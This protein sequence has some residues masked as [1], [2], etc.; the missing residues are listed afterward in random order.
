M[1][2][3]DSNNSVT[4]PALNA[5]LTS[6][7]ANTDNRASM[8]KRSTFKLNKLPSIMEDDH[9]AFLSARMM[10]NQNSQSKRGTFKR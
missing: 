6:G 4:N 1:T 3:N 8:H 2:R 7:A 5:A 9:N 10:A